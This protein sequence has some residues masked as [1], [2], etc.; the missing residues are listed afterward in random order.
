M[1]QTPVQFFGLRVEIE[2]EEDLARH[3]IHYYYY[4]RFANTCSSTVA[5][6]F[7]LLFVQVTRCFCLYIEGKLKNLP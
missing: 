1:I 6:A 5:L 4:F 2:D 7:K 3:W